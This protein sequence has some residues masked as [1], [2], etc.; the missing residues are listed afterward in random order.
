MDCVKYIRHNHDTVAMSSND[1]SF[2]PLFLYNEL[3]IEYSTSVF[4]IDIISVSN[5]LL[6]ESIQPFERKY[7]TVQIN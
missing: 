5:N 6:L 4:S 1:S 3:S 2:D 7:Q